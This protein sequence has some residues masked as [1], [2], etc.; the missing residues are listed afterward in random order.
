MNQTTEQNPT[1][2]RDVATRGFRSPDPNVRWLGDAVKSWDKKTH[3]WMA[4][5]G[6]PFDG[7]TAS[8]RRGSR[9]APSRLREYV[10]SLTTYNIEH[11]SDIT[12]NLYDCGDVD[13]NIIDFDETMRRLRIAAEPI[14]ENAQH[15][16]A[17][18][19]DHSLT[20]ELVRAARKIAQGEIGLIQFDAHNDMRTKWGQHSGFWL[21]Q[22]V[23]EGIVKGKHVYQIGLRGSLY[24]QY[25]TEYLRQKGFRYLTANAFH[26]M[27]LEKTLEDAA[28]RLKL[29]KEV[30]ITFDVDVVDQA[31]AP[32]T[33]HPSPGGLTS[34]EALRLVYGLATKLPVRWFDIMEVSPPHDVGEQTVA[35]GGELATQ[36]IHAR[37]N[38]NRA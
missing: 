5:I 15:V 11:D 23:D 27:G 3:M 28:N 12:E 19:G 38:A 22:L 14:F 29:V 31:F 24:S 16:V 36:F 7:G 34:D 2:L 21:R 17:L 30:Y 8:A 26:E 18:G 4:I 6:I 25:Y 33:D 37:F 10:Y 13:V 20:Y 1:Y 32:G 35:V 9:Y